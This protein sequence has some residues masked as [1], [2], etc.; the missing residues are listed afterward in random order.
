MNTTCRSYNV[1][2]ALDA[3]GANRSSKNIDK[4]IVSRLKQL[5]GDRCHE[6]EDIYYLYSDTIRLVER[7]P[8]VLNTIIY[9][10]SLL[11]DVHFIADVCM[12]V[13]GSTLT[14]ITKKRNE[15][16]VLCEIYT[17]MNTIKRSPF[18]VI[19]PIRWHSAKVQDDIRGLQM[20]TICVTRVLGCRLDP[21]DV[22]TMQVIVE[23]TKLT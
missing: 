5:Y 2:V 22:R 18:I 4:L 23:Y 17:P 9:D 13:K 15:E 3:S 21:C 19:M 11:F 20:N 14:C 16:G 1:Q 12:F 10:G 6:Q 8:G 7:G